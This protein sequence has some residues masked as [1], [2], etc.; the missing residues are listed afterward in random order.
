[1]ECLIDCG[2]LKSAFEYN[3]RAKKAFPEDTLFKSYTK[4]VTGRLQS[5]FGDEYNLV[6]I[7]EYPDR[8][9]VRR[10]LYPWNEYEPDRFSSE[11]LQFL[12]DEMAK[13]APKLEVKIA[14]LPILSPGGS[15]SR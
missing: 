7:S 9:M 12:N 11:C 13:V 3:T 15:N 6:D 2:C 5:H 14:T 8:G 4:T 1:M 10:E